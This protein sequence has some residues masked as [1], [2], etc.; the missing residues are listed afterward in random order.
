MSQ[1]N[2][3]SIRPATFSESDQKA[4]II[5]AIQK[6]F[7]DTD[8]REWPYYP[9][10]H[11]LNYFYEGR[12]ASEYAEFLTNLLLYIAKNKLTTTFENEV[13]EFSLDLIKELLT[14]FNRLASQPDYYAF[15][16][17]FGLNHGRTATPSGITS[18][19]KDYLTGPDL[20]RV[21]AANPDTF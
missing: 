15:I 21:L 18:I 20:E 4:L 11:L 9:M 7:P 3:T 19:A 14:F 12:G 5:D 8:F 13:D 6:R 16:A 1:R 10:G 2:T 17:Y